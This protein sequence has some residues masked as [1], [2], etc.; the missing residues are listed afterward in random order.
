MEDMAEERGWEGTAM[1]MGTRGAAA[2]AMVE[3]ELAVAE[4]VAIVAAVVKGEAM[5]GNPVEALV[6]DTCSECACSPK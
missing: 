6:E 4:V 3:L 5:V 2:A 1:V